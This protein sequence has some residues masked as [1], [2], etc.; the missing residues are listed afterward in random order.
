MR[1]GAE[2]SAVQ[3]VE[4]YGLPAEVPHLISNLRRVPPYVLAQ[5]THHEPG[6]PS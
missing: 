6:G 1:P 4:T 5:I 3:S 2:L